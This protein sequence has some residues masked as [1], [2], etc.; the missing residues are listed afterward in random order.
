MFKRLFVPAALLASVLATEAF[1]RGSSECHRHSPV[2]AHFYSSAVVAK[3]DSCELTSD[4][5]YDSAQMVMVRM[6]A[7]LRGR[8]RAEAQHLVCIDG[9]EP[10]KVAEG[11]AGFIEV[12]GVCSIEGLGN[13]QE[14][15]QPV[16]WGI[17]H[18]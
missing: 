7:S 8:Y 16:F 11:L 18:N 6:C 5:A 12:T 4:L 3:R 17:H 9:S 2:N 13:C 14:S 1:A 10:I 15:G